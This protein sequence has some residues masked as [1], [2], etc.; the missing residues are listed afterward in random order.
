MNNDR[1]QAQQKLE[2]CGQKRNQN[3]HFIAD[4]T[5]YTKRYIRNYKLVWLKEISPISSQVILVSFHYFDCEISMQN[6]E[7]GI[8]VYRN[9]KV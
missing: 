9:Y 6:K 7:T 1:I 3:A 4:Y 8:F 2:I 5:V